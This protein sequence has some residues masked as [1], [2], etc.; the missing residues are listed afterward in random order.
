MKPRVRDVDPELERIKKLVSSAGPYP[1]VVKVAQRVF[2]RIPYL[3]TQWLE[4]ME[5]VPVSKRKGEMVSQIM[6]RIEEFIRDPQA[7]KELF[8]P[9]K[10]DDYYTYIELVVGIARSTAKQ[11]T[12]H[13]LKDYP[14]NDRPSYQ[15]EDEGYSLR[16]KVKK[17]LA[18]MGVAT[19]VQTETT[20]DRIW[21]RI[22]VTKSSGDRKKDKKKLRNI[23]PTIVAYFPGEPYLYAPNNLKQ[24]IGDA[25]VTSFEATNLTPL[26]LSGKHIDSLRRLR[27]GRDGRAGPAKTAPTKDRFTVFPTGEPGEEVN[28]TDNTL[29]KLNKIVV[30][31][32][33]EFK[34]CDELPEKAATLMM[35]KPMNAT[36][37]VVGSDVI[38]GLMD[39]VDQGIIDPC[40]PWVSNLSTAG[41]N[42]FDLVDGGR[43]TVRD[44]DLESVVSHRSVASSRFSQREN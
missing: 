28:T 6:D 30:R 23:R 7:A 19:T 4:E 37:E 1:A 17:A 21:L 29:P 41:R 33:S 5:T 14:T 34:A 35:G 42:R 11:W 12:V 38:G 15:M 44:A 2:Q 13:L 39:L 3:V 24:E 20:E 27:L 40:P 8:M 18:D 22:A 9:Y 16:T 31:F 36:L 10:T 26:P 25:L 43:A 32:E